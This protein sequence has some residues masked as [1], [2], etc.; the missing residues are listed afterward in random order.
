LL[1]ASGLSLSK[2]KESTWRRSNHTAGRKVKGV[3]ENGFP[4]EYREGNTSSTMT[5]VEAL[6]EDSSQ[7]RRED[8]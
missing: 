1:H 5:E 4:R 3:I 8:P 2:N 7:V 6:G